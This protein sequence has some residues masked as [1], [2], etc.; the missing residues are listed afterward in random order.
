MQ[1]CCAATLTVH[2]VKPASCAVRY[3]TKYV[4]KPSTVQR[5]SPTHLAC[6]PYIH[7]TYCSTL[8]RPTVHHPQPT[9]RTPQPTN[10]PIPT[11]IHPPSFSTRSRLL[12]AAPRKSWGVNSCE[13]S[14]SDRSSASKTATSVGFGAGEEARAVGGSGVPLRRELITETPLAPMLDVAFQYCRGHKTILLFLLHYNRLWTGRCMRCAGVKIQGCRATSSMMICNEQVICNTIL[15]CSGFADKQVHDTKDWSATPSF[16]AECADNARQSAAR[17]AP[18]F[19]SI[20]TN[21]GSCDGLAALHA[22]RGAR[23]WVGV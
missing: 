23:H 15:S 5:H 1:K 4:T 16:T 20:T 21:R 8:T 7:S 22:A 6:Q 11:T 17:Q 2:L 12:A 9:N 14:K 19:I 13:R 18:T 10:Q 3:S